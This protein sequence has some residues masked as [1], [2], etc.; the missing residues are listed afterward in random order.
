MSLFGL[1]KRKHRPTRRP[2]LPQRWRTQLRIESLEDRRTPAVYLSGDVLVIDGTGN[3]DSA[4]VSQTSRTHP[5]GLFTEYI[6][7]VSLNGISQSFSSAS[8]AIN[9]V[10]FNG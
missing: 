6:T 4:L 2:L 3:N 1:L 9:R 5:S 10:Q 8:V 7:T